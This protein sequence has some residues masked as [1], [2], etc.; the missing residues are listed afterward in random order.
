MYCSRFCCL[1]EKHFLQNYAYDEVVTTFRHCF[2]L[3]G[4][5]EKLSSSY[6]LGSCLNDFLFTT[7]SNFVWHIHA[8]S[9][10][11]YWTERNIW[12]ITVTEWCKKAQQ[13]NGE[14]VICRTKPLSFSNHIVSI[15][16][17]LWPAIGLLIL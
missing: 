7:K 9:K 13:R 8:L 16:P 17:L 15:R 5:S 2:V 12:A 14:T 6:F 1:F 4:V 11:S 3:V 10:S